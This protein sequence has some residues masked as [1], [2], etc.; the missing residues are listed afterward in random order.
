VARLAQD[1]PQ[2]CH[3]GGVI[4]LLAL[5]SAGAGGGGFGAGSCAEVQS[6]GQYTYYRDSDCNVIGRWLN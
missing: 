4:G 5:V 1:G 6:D 3:R 2:L